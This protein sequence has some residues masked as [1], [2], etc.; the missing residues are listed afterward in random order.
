MSIKEAG[1]AIAKW[2]APLLSIIGLIAVAAVAYSQ[3]DEIR[4][5]SKHNETRFQRIE[6]YLVRIGEK[7]GVRF[8]E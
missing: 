2:W 5:R 3:V 7:V 6:W 4:Q 8:P 1:D